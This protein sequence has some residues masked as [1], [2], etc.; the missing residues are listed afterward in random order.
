M[1]RPRHQNHGLRASAGP[2]GFLGIVGPA[3]P[4]CIALDVGWGVT[5][6]ATA[7]ASEVAAS[8]AGLGDVPAFDRLR[9]LL[10]F[11]EVLDDQIRQLEDECWT[12]GVTR[13]ALARVL[14]ISRA[15]LYRRHNGMRGS[16]GP[17]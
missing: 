14:G 1:L 4:T 9:S 15:E 6:R 11:R 8:A 17:P 7:R 13:H 5:L 2:V 10:L 12:D 3:V 16:Q